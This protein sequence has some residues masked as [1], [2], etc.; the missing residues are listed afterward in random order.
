MTNK[1]WKIKNLRLGWGELLLKKETL[2]KEIWTIEYK[3]NQIK[4]ELLRYGIHQT[5]SELGEDKADM[6]ESDHLDNCFAYNGDTDI[7]KL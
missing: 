4:E 5:I 2:L 3:L 7:H 1:E 6:G